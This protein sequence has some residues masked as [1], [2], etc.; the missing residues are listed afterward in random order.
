MARMVTGFYTCKPVA[1]GSIDHQTF[2]MMVAIDTLI[3]D[4]S[5]P[6]LPVLWSSTHPVSN[7]I[8]Q[9]HPFCCSK[10]FK[11]Q[12]STLVTKNCVLEPLERSYVIVRVFWKKKTKHWQKCLNF[13]KSLFPNRFNL[14]HPQPSLF[15]SVLES[16]LWYFSSLA[17]HYF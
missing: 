3:N 17:N 2:G 15:L 10:Q 7:T 11:V 6:Y 4:D 9:S 5:V 16:P 13:S 14:L 8:T 12:L 1:S